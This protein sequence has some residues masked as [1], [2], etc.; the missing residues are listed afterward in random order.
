[1]A[2]TINTNVS[3]LYGQLYLDRNSKKYGETLQRLESGLRVNNASDDPAG[4]AIAEGMQK[5]ISGLAA[6]SRNG[7]YGVNLIQTAQGAM[8]QILGELQT[9]NQL[10]VQAASG[11]NSDDDRTNLNSQ[12]T[13]LLDEINRTANV[14]TFNG[15]SLLT[16]GSLSIQIGANNSSNDQISITLSD[17]TTGS[18]GLNIA[19]EAVDTVGHAQSAID[20][21]GD[22]ISSITSSLASLGAASQNL[23]FAIQS[24]NATAVNLSASRS[25]IMD[26]DVAAE[27]S[28]LAKENIL[29]QS[30]VAM[31]SQAN[32]A[33]QLVLQLLKQ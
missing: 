21:I 3:S 32:S 27:T 26:A 4:L 24:N 19:S 28:D 29:Q 20:A 17:A 14:T 8:Q 5:S 13:A 15:V 18:A 22:A 6:G 11:T 31:L 33:P 10:A 16:G 25:A 1:M 7:Q 30:T 9:M 23:N 2:I 12:F